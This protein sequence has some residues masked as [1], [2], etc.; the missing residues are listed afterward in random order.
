MFSQKN[1]KFER[2]IPLFLETFLSST[3]AG[4]CVS[5]CPILGVFPE[6]LT[7]MI[8]AW[9]V[10]VAG[11]SDGIFVTRAPTR[12]ALLGIRRH[13]RYKGWQRANFREN[14]NLPFSVRNNSS[15]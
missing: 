7:R 13:P 14:G 15:V 1:G 3:L 4:V 11:S 6:G 8:P 9:E 12:A 2:K 10:P 5:K